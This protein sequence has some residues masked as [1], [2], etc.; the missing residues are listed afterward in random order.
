MI[1]PQP[2]RLLGFMA[3]DACVHPAVMQQQHV[4]GRR[5]LHRVTIDG[6]T[7]PMIVCSGRHHKGGPQTHYGARQRRRQAL[8][9]AMLDVAQKL[10][11]PSCAMA[12]A[13]PSHHR[14]GRGR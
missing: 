4:A 14:A 12:R 7:L 1:R 9:A 8:K 10:A 2:W 6:D 13:R 3:T 5:L 11:Q